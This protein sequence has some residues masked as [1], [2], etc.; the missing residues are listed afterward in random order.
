MNVVVLDGR[1]TKDPE[2]KMKN[3]KEILLFTIASARDKDHTDFIEC[4]AFENNARFISKYFKKGS[5]INI[6][7]TLNQSLYEK[8]G[9]KYS[10]TKVIA[11]VITFPIRTKEEQPQKID[12]S[13]VTDTDS[14]WES[15]KDVQLSP[16]D[17][18]FY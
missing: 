7:G 12:E 15:A 18:P 6:V 17:L 8:E 3:D 10:I 13:K 4:V 9:K 11:N 16:D 14:V 2:V 5:G 1:L